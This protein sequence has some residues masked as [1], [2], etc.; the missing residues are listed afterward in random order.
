MSGRK[1]RARTVVILLAL[2]GM[3][4]LSGFA[5]VI[6]PVRDRSIIVGGM[7]TFVGMGALLVVLDRLKS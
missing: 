4:V 5:Y 6:T 2:L 7:F 3:L 1:L